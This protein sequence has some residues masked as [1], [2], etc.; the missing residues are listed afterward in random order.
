MAEST[1]W[2]RG[3][4]DNDLLLYLYVF[5]LAI[6]PGSLLLSFDLLRFH[7][8]LIFRDGLD[9]PH[10]SC[11][12]HY[13]RQKPSD[14]LLAGVLSSH[15]QTPRVVRRRYRPSS[16]AIPLPIHHPPNTHE[17]IMPRCTCSAPRSLRRTIHDVPP[18]FNRHGP[19]AP[20]PTQ[21]ILPHNH[22]VTRRQFYASLTLQPP[23]TAYRYAP[24]ISSSSSG[25]Q[26]PASFSCERAQAH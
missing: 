23:P 7:S 5:V 24:P 10:L 25:Y 20:L 2:R 26:Q 4:V 22:V 9:I 18:I 19:P 11:Y 1:G 8:V 15:F 14:L 17:T 12:L 21:S 3:Y 16:V 6:I 13:P